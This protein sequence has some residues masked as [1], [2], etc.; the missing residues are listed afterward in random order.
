MVIHKIKNNTK[1]GAHFFMLD[2][3]TKYVYNNDD[4]DMTSAHSQ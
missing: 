4:K 1:T 3:L 2:V